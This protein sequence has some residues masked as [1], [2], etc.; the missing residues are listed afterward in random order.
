MIQRT[1]IDRW[2]VNNSG[3]DI[4]YYK[5]KHVFGATQT[6]L[7]GSSQGVSGAL[8]LNSLASIS[9]NF[10]SNAGLA[11]AATSFLRYRV[12]GIKVKVTWFPN[13]ATGLANEPIVGFI[14]ATADS[15]SFSTPAITTTPE[16]RF[17]KYRILNGPASGRPTTVTYYLSSKLIGGADRIVT[18]D[19]DYTGTTN[20]VLPLFNDPVSGARWRW[21]IF[22]MNGGTVVLN[23]TYPFKIEIT[24]YCKFWS[25]RAYT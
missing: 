22:T 19:K 8:Q 12:S 10:G 7:T 20:T 23:Q 13:T 25:K 11:L 2:G 1:K 4:L 21:G 24:A 3:N 18:T 9:T 17:M 16:Q 14:E 5:S 6:L 15:S